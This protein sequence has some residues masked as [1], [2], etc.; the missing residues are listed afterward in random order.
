MIGPHG[1]A[2]VDTELRVHGLSGL[3]IAD[4]SVTPSPISGDTNA[5]A[6]AIAEHAAHLLAGWGKGQCLRPDRSTDH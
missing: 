1:V 5:T 6:F 3:R 4:A 2:V